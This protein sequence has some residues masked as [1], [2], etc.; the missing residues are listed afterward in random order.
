MQTESFGQRIRYLRTKK[1]MT[2]KELAKALYVSES[3]VSGWERGR[4]E[5]SIDFIIKLTASLQTSLNYL[6]IGNKKKTP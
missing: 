3:T 4:A 5:P 2:Q 6:I 1:G